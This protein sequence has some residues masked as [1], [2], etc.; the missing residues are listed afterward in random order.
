MTQLQR[1]CLICSRVVPTQVITP[2]VTATPWGSLKQVK[3]HK[4]Q[5]AVLVI[6]IVCSFFFPLAGSYSWQVGCG[7]KHGAKKTNIWACPL[8]NIS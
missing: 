4:L 8:A 6:Y 1:V 7:E 2:L 3:F 5:W